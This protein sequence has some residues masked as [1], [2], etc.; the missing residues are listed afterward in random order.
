MEKLSDFEAFISAVSVTVLVNVAVTSDINGVAIVVGRICV[1]SSAE[2]V[3][4]PRRKA[5]CRG[6]F[7]TTNLLLEN[8]CNHHRSETR[9]YT[10]KLMQGFGYI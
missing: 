10:D 7:L 3:G 9:P 2:L 6:S 8:V 5:Y 1:D 4:K